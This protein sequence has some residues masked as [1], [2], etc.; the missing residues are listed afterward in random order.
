VRPALLVRLRRPFAPAM[1]AERA[2]KTT[3]SLKAPP[4]AGRCLVHVRPPSTVRRMVAMSPTAQPRPGPSRT[5]ANRAWVV[6]LCRVAHVLPPS[7]LRR[8]A[9]PSP[10]AMPV[11]PSR[12]PNV[13]PKRATS[14]GVVRSV[15]VA[16]PSLVR[17]TT[18]ASPTAQTRRR[19]AAHT[20]KSVVLTRLV[21]RRHDAP[22]SR[23]RSTVPPS[24]T[25]Q[26]QSPSTMTT[27]LSELPWGRGFSHDQP[28]ACASVGNAIATRTAASTVARTT[29]GAPA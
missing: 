8:I 18:P 13:T 12:P 22:P 20:P 4:M 5:T 11:R 14:V 15:H 1:T 16:P 6:R 24:P 26:P 2:S 7:P 9:P 3:M 27:S 25:A 19:S 29:A 23:V 28:A 17:R 21:W 10:T